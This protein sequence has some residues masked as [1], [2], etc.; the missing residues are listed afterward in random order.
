MGSELADPIGPGRRLGRL[1][2]LRDAKRRFSGSTSGSAVFSQPWR[3]PSFKMVA[4]HLSALF[5]HGGYNVSRRRLPIRRMKPTAW[6]WRPTISTTGV[7]V[8]GHDYDAD[9]I[10][11]GF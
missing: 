10:L 5:R 7:I 8:T 9:L 3:G 11:T 1:S 4:I 6:A 2:I